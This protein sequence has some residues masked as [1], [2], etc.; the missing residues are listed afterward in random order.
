MMAM[1]KAEIK[2]AKERIMVFIKDVVKRDEATLKELMKT[3]LPGFNIESA[4]KEECLIVI[5]NWRV[6]ELFPSR[7]LD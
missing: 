6:E 5:L 7:R 2:S 1:T 3:Y 4:S